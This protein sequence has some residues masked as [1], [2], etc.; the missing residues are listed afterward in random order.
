MFLAAL[1]KDA[2][3]PVLLGAHWSTFISFRLI[4]STIAGC[5]HPFPVLQAPKSLSS[6]QMPQPNPGP[7]FL[8]HQPQ[9]PCLMTPQL[10]PCPISKTHGA[11]SCLL[12]VAQ[13]IPWAWSTFHLST[14]QFHHLPG[15]EESRLPAASPLP[16][17][18]LASPPS[19]GA[20]PQPC[21]CHFIGTDTSMLSPSQMHTLGEEAR[22]QD[23]GWGCSGSLPC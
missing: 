15:P 23:D 16:H 17:P 20:P 2:A 22:E 21:A 19:P 9:L 4:S 8:P 3:G 10:P 7:D 6:L 11:P 14:Y 18:T 12:A 1:L 13:V 5:P